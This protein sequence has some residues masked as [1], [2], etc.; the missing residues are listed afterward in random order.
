MPIY[1]ICPETLWRDAQAA[2]IFAGAPIDLA[3]GYIHFSTAA[4]VEETAAKHFAGQPDLLLLT[5]DESAL[6]AALRYE[7]SRGGAL[8][9][10]LYGS[11]PLAAVSAAMPLPLGPDGRHVFPAGLLPAPDAPAPFDPAAAGWTALDARGLW[12][13]IGPLWTKTLPEGRPV[14]ALPLEERHLNR[15]GI[16]HGGT[17]MSFLDEAMGM[18]SWHGS[19]RR[20]QVTIQLDT[21]FIAAGMAGDFME[22][23]C[24]IV[25][26]T[27]SLM[28][29]AGELKVGNRLVATARGVWKFLG[30]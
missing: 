12:L 23:D 28:F 6:G 21:H 29:V 25:R 19:G 13:A 30:A 11:L 7:P 22:A 14:Y 20:R 16:V 24:H 8:F 17:L 1:K 3:D 4:Q 9:P 5:I 15:G 2:G 10:H 26:Q 27:R 18:T